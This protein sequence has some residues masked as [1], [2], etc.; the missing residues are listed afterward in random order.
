MSK[1][2]YCNEC[3]DRICN[4][5]SSK[6]A[7]EDPPTCPWSGIVGHEVHAPFTV[8][9]GPADVSKAKVKDDG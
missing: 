6:N 4:L 5:V 2:W 3:G 7:K 9:V 8:R 1:K